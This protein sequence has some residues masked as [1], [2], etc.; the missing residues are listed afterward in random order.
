MA[1]K[2]R[3]LPTTV[4]L[5]ASLLAAAPLAHA[6][7][8]GDMF[9]PG[10]WMGG[11][12][13]YDEYYYDGPYG[14]YGPYGGGPWGG[15]P[16][17]G[18]GGYG[19]YGAPGYGGGAPYGYAPPAVAPG[20]AAPAAPAAPAPTAPAGSAGGDAKDREIEALKRRIDQL[21]NRQGGGQAAPPPSAGGG[22]WPS[23]PA[24]RPMDQY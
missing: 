24:F 15:A 22:E 16:G 14:A 17:Y 6:F 18:Y 7:N 13:D 19:P 12:D 21:E 5:A 23:A 10:R 8:F 9:N 2:F 3:K 4:T 11:G 20:Y 1:K